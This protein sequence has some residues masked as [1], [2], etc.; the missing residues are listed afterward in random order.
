MR[1]L[2]TLIRSLPLGRWLLRPRPCHDGPR[3]PHPAVAPAR[4]RS[5]TAGFA[6]ALARAE[7]PSSSPVG[8]IDES[9]LD[10]AP[11]LPQSPLPGAEETAAALAALHDEAP[12]LVD[13]PDA[14]RSSAEPEARAGA[15]AADGPRDG[16]GGHGGRATDPPAPPAAHL[17][18]GS[19]PAPEPA[20]P[21]R[22]VFARAGYGTDTP[23][24]DW[25]AEEDLIVPARFGTVGHAEMNRW[26]LPP[27]RLPPRPPLPSPSRNASPSRREAAPAE[28]HAPD[29]WPP[30]RRFRR[31]NW[32]PSRPPLRTR[33][34]STAREPFAEP[35][36]IPS[37]SAFWEPEGRVPGA[38]RHAI[39]RGLGAR[40]GR[41]APRRA[42]P[43][44]RPR[45]PVDHGP[46]DAAAG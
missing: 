34:S 4:E 24:P 5:R 33:R 30:T 39:A 27:R 13:Q 18:A 10:T 11:P 16:P 45:G 2:L 22:H 35:P 21:E 36:I 14:R 41:P 28:R 9:L 43:A 6:E 15:G 38:V 31:S 8:E 12:S 42:V 32:P 7:D 25:I 26:R 40:R 20:E 1:P 37:E 29:P 17:A 44:R 46:G 3:G 23:E 19:S